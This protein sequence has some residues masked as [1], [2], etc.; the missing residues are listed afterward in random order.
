M[1]EEDRLEALVARTSVLTT[2]S[3]R[4][5]R[6]NRADFLIAIDWEPT[7]HLEIETTDERRSTFIIRRLISELLEEIMGVEL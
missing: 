1:V 6:L 5:F 4:V 2:V 7:E 3:G